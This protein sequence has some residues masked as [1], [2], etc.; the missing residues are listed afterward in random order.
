MQTIL[1]KL[2]DEKLYIYITTYNQGTINTV[3]KMLIMR[4]C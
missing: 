1:R 2:M 3:I 4:I